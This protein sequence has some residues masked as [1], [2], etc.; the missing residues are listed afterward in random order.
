M[1]VRPSSAGD[2]VASRVHGR[3]LVWS[4]DGVVTG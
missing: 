3:D 2:E 1:I 4:D